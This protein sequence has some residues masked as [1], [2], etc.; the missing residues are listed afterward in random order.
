M[1]EYLYS[2]EKGSKKF[3]CP[4]CDQKTFV[5]YID[6]WKNCYL[7]AEVGRCDRE[8]KCGYHR[9]PD[10]NTKL[11]TTTELQPPKPPTYHDLDLLHSTQMRDDNFCRYILS[12]Y[13]VGIVEYV[14]SRYKIGSANTITNLSDYKN[15]TIFW[16]IDRENNIRHGK[17]ILYNPK[18]LKRVKAPDGRAI[19]NSVRSLKGLKDFNLSQCLFGLHL[20]KDVNEIEKQRPIGLVESEKTAILM[21][22][23]KSEY[24]WLATG[25]KAMFGEK[26]LKDIKDQKIVAYPDTD[27]FDDWTKVAANL[28]SQGYDITISR[29]LQ[30]KNLPSGTDLADVFLNNQ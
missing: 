9:K 24:T 7:E 13:P 10:G 22:I 25:T 30:D 23:I 18:T 20:V 27:A 12:K 11:G 1:N 28:N 15:A 3:I 26:Y 16:Q 14:W 6:I 21:A 19:I 5:R 8:A 4:N 17:V 2:L 29:V